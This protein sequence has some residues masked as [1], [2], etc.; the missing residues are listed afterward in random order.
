MARAQTLIRVLGKSDI[1]AIYHSDTKRSKETA[2]PLATHLPNIT[3]KQINDAPAM[4][5][6]ILANHAGKTVL[7]IGHSNTVPE[8]INRLSGRHMPDIN[9]SEFD[10]LFIVT[11]LGTG[12]ASV[13]SLKYGEPTP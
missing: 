2:A 11:V 9:D 10:N 8:L 1:E 5:N 12:K 13:T 4:K 3:K 7:V 6:D